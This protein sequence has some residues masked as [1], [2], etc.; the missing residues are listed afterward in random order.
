[1]RFALPTALPLL[2]ALPLAPYVGSL[3]ART[4][5][6]FARDEERPCNCTECPDYPAMSPVD[7]ALATAFD[8]AACA[9]RWVSG[10]RPSSR[11]WLRII[12]EVDRAR[13]L[14]RARGWLADPAAYHVTPPAVDAPQLN[15]RRSRRRSFLHLT[16]E[17]GYEPR[18]GEPGRERWLGYTANRTA[19]AGRWHAIMIR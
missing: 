7:I 12:N 2:D 16:F 1:M 6:A 8:R 10:A 13:T 5:P 19:H 18:S 11:E 17:S 3:F 15:S 14:F 9:Y 4:K